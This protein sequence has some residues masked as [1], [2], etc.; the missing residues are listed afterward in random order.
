MSCATAHRLCLLCQLGLCQACQLPG[1]VPSASTVLRIPLRGTRPAAARDPG[2][3]TGLSGPDGQGQARG[4]GQDARAAL[5]AL[6]SSVTRCVLSF[7]GPGRGCTGGLSPLST[8][9]PQE[10][11][12]AAE[13]HKELGP[14]YSDA[15]IE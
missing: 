7:R 1:P 14:A 5:A 8:L 2:A 15:V 12:A 11:R 13:T 6:T 4:Q 10:I 3:F 9:D